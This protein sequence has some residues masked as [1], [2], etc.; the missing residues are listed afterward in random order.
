MYLIDLGD[1][2][3]ETKQL[4]PGTKQD[5]MFVFGRIAGSPGEEGDIE[6]LMLLG[7]AEPE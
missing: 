6:R 4:A 2:M 1:A 5:S 7:D 3:V